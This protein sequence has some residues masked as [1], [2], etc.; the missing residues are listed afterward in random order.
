MQVTF[1]MELITGFNIIVF[2]YVYHHILFPTMN[3]LGANKSTATTIRASF[4]LSAFVFP[5][6]LSF[7]ILG[8]CTFGSS[9][10]ASVLTNV[11]KEHNTFSYIIG[12]NFCLVLAC[13]IPYMFFPTK[14]SFL[15]IFDEA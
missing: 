13:H 8:I 4:I 5:I 10:E 9:V 7:A 3:S 12:V 2:A 11:G 15:I 1:D 6:Y 14:E